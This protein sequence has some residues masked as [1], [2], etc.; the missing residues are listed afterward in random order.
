MNASSPRI[1]DIIRTL[2]GLSLDQARGYLT[3][4]L[5]TLDE[6]E[7]RALRAALPAGELPKTIA[8]VEAGTVELQPNEFPTQR[9]AFPMPW[10][11]TE[12]A[13]CAPG[14]STGELIRLARPSTSRRK[15]LALSIAAV[16][17][18]GC[19]LA[20]LMPNLHAPK[21]AAPAEV[22]VEVPA[23][24]VTPVVPED[25]ELDL[26]PLPPKKKV[27]APATK[28][29]SSPGSSP[30]HGGL[31]QEADPFATRF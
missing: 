24:V 1:I 10:E 18:L 9:N 7:A 30:R 21:P 26:V 20:L 27:R 31:A 23:V 5:A 8:K 12:E 19:A 28:A 4:A 13:Q 15:A 11:P 25:P 2:R 6:A 16:V 22:P 17:T 29:T 14:P 3:E